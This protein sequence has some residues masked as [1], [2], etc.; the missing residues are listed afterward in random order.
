MFEKAI[1]KSNVQKFKSSKNIKNFLKLFE[2]ASLKS[3]VHINA[4]I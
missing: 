1:T 2:N 4:F 3:N